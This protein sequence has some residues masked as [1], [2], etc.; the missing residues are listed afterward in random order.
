MTVG[1]YKD[2]PSRGC[3]F[4]EWKKEL[5]KMGSCGKQVYG[6]V[7][8]TELCQEHFEYVCH[9]KGFGREEIK[10]VEAPA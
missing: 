3:Q 2:P 1:I 7:G 10:R 8:K 5:Q 9:N 6:R 4:G